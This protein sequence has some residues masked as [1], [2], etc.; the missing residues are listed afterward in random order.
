M[1]MRW[2][3]A[4]FALFGMSAGAS[5]GDAAG[6][7]VVAR[8]N[9]RV[10]PLDR[11]TFYDEPIQGALTRRGLG[12]VTGGGTALFE[13]G[14]IRFIDIEILLRDVDAGV[15]FVIGQL[16]ALGAPKGSRL[17]FPEGTGLEEIAF[18]ERE[19]VAVYLDGVGLPAK[20]Y[21]TSDLN[22]VVAAF[23]QALGAKGE[24]R[25]DWQGPRETALYFY[26]R[27]AEEM[28]RLMRLVLHATPLCQGARVVTIAPVQE[29]AG[30]PQDS[31]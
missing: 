16:A 17:M 23:E 27:D 11:G 19:G 3:G 14:E 15:P 22:L 12:E 1:V 24:H 28:K 13:S 29:R 31:R 4:L 9:E 6:T 18:G 21:A 30:Q 5:H 8:I 26:G 25:G 10:M 2:L 20:V 7:L